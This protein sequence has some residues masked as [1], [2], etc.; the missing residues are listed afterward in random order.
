MTQT[1]QTFSTQWGGRTLT[2]TTGKYASP[3]NGSCLVQYGETVV[4]ATATMSSGTRDGID[5]LPLM[6]DYEEKLY[7]AGRIK[8]SRFIKTEG[9]PTDEAVLTSRFVDRALRPFFDP[10]LRHDI[11]VIVTVLAF[12]GEND[13]DIVALFAAS[14]ALHMSD[15]PWAGPVAPIRIGQ[16]SGEWVINPSYEVRAKSLLDLSFAGDKDTIVMVEAGANEVEESVVLDAFWFGQKHLSDPIKLIE[17][18]RAAA[19]KEKQVITYPND[20]AEAAQ[21]EVLLPLIVT[22]ID[23]LFF[24]APKATKRERGAAKGVLHNWAKSWMTEKYGADVNKSW[25]GGFVDGMIENQ[26]TNRILAEGKRVDGRGLQEIRPLTIEVGLL[27]RVHGT[28]HF[29]RGETQVLSVVTLGAPGDEQTLDGMEIVGKKRYFHHYNFPP[30]SVG[31]VKPLRGPGR[32]E[33]GHGALAEKALLPMLPEKEAF[34]YAIRVVSEVFSSNGSSSMASTCGSTLALMDA[35]LP[36]KAPVAGIAM[37]LASVPN[38]AWK[39]LTDLQDLEDGT[40]GMDFK[41]AGSRKGIT[42]IQMDTKTLGLSKEII[43][44][45]F[46]R[47]REGLSQILDAMQVTI[48]E[49]RA[50]LSPYAPRII[51]IRIN[52]ERIGDVIGPGGK[53]IN[54]IIATTGVQS[55]DIEDDGLVMITSANAEGAK[56]AEKW[57]NDLTREVNAGE[58]FTGKVTRL[59]DFGA[60]VEILPKQEGLVH[61]SEM[62]PWRVAKVTDIVNTGDKVQ[63]KVKEIDDLGRINLSM[64]DAPGNVY[65][66]KPTD[67]GAGAPNKGYIPNKTPRP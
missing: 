64:K 15:I 39:V 62:A 33:V 66:E 42:A 57:V 50:D 63:V 23:R 65:P 46:Q 30:Y 58:F 26:V 38:G 52:P 29:L 51:T 47:A 14:C 35:G 40:G 1:P 8:G 11:Q 12:D 5:Y 16:I 9:R 17:E 41:I 34:P 25:L 48:A 43:I 49:P 21:K 53:M 18:V 37:G 45:T 54:E 22:E 31:E 24:D 28:G 20:A 60:F 67:T 19:G 4:L 7:A 6:V 36:I 13:P 59:M 55:I 3:A 2:V 44:E 56:A 10:R 32:R 61:I 27:P